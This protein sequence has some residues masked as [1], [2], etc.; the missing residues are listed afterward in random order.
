MTSGFFPFMFLPCFRSSYVLAQN[1]SPHPLC[2]Y[3]QSAPTLK[4]SVGLQITSATDPTS[5]F[6]EVMARRMALNQEGMLRPQHFKPAKDRSQPDETPKRQRTSR[7]PNNGN[8][9]EE[10]SR[11][12]RL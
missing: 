5:S 1:A 9:P 11:D 10:I 7:V 6:E 8:T 3:N 12:S 2:F 4:T